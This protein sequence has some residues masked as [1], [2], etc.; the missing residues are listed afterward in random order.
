MKDT[1]SNKL[2]SFQSTLAVALDERN[3][4]LWLYQSPAAFGEGIAAA[5]T[6]VAGLASAGAEQ[7]VPVT[8]ATD[9]LRGL[10]ARF[11]SALHPLAR[12]TFR[13]LGKLGR[14]EEAAK[15]DLTPTS[16]HNARAVALAGLGETVLELAEP[17][18]HP[19]TGGQPAP[20]EKYGVTPALVGQVDDLWNRYS[21]AVGAPA[22]ARAHRKA[23]TD[24]LPAQFATVEEQFA[25]LDDLIVQ[26]NTTA[27]G[28]RFVDAWFNA[29][30]VVDTGRRANRPAPAPVP[31]PTETV[32]NP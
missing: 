13:C 3:Q 5:R 20:G 19:V 32:P 23:L 12:A 28:Q 27:A 14:T 11:E 17:L 29:R 2:A 7:S 21:T 6:A 22:G 18:T 25:E 31:A 16:L 1:L 30:R 26:I 9:V 15:V 4:P 24:A 8:G 10:R